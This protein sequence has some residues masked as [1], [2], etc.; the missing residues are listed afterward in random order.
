MNKQKIF[1][2][3]V[4]DMKK[5]WD[6]GTKK[7]GNLMNECDKKRAIQEVYEELVDVSNHAFLLYLRQLEMFEKGV[8]K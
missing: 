5:R 3:Y 2:Q 4:K 6:K 8:L 7:Y 1:K